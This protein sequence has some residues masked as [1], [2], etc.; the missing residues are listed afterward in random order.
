MWSAAAVA[1]F[2]NSCACDVLLGALL[3]HFAQ[4]DGLSFELGDELLDL[5]DLGPLRGFIVLGG[6]HVLPGGEVRAFQSDRAGGGD[7][8]ERDGDR[9]GGSGGPR[10]AGP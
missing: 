7:E 6:L 4:R 3:G 9:P 2:S 10:D 5:R 1:S 8:R